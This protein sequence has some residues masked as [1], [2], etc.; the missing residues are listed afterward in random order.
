MAGMAIAIPGGAN[1]SET[2]DTMGKSGEI[3]AK[4]G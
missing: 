1:I 3:G 4:T 2:G